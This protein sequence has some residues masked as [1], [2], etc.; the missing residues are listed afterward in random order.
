MQ[1]M[2]MEQIFRV[3][4]LVTYEVYSHFYVLKLVILRI[5]EDGGN[6]LCNL[7]FL[8]LFI[9]RMDICIKLYLY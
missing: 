9:L 5:P 8:D 2:H 6:G 4:I 3:L 7:M 1:A